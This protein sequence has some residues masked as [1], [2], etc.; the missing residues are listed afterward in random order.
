VI[1]VFVALLVGWGNV[2][3]ALLAP[4]T[5]LPGGSWTFVIAG[6]ALTVLAVLVAW[7]GGLDLRALGLGRRGMWRGGALG[8]AA[9]AGIAAAGATALQIAP[10]I[11]GRPVVYDPLLGV[12]A[13][14]LAMHIFLFLPLATVLPEEIAFRGTLIGLLRDSGPRAILV[15]AA[16][17]ALWHAAVAVAT[18]ERT[19]L[20]GTPWVVPAIL[21]ALAVV[22]AGGVV[23][24]W[25]RMATGTLATT[26][27]AHWSFNATLL[28]ALWALL[29]RPAGSA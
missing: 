24:A 29:P 17:F 12:S 19:T 1:W 25:L 5:L 4:T 13:A 2:G 28:V 11:T 20:V 6:V 18:V 9:G 26:I 27:A 15:S 7:R 10:L 23:L 16:A 3:T 21:G 22:F 8:L 14:A